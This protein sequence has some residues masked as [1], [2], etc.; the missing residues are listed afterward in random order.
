MKKT[1]LLMTFA[2]VAIFTLSL[3]GLAEAGKKAAKVRV[4]AQSID[5]R[6]ISQMIDTTER[7][8]GGNSN[9]LPVITWGGDIA[10]I[11]ANGNQKTTAAGSIFA[12]QGLSFNL[13]REDVFPKQ[14]ES[15][16]KCESPYL[17]GTMGM[18]NM[19]AEAA[20]RDSRTKMVVVYQHTW[21]AGGDVMVV[22][23]NVKNVKSLK[24]RYDYRNYVVDI[25]KTPKG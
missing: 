13:M 16:L 25:Y 14:V 23:E 1:R 5:V 12:Q 4:K 24:G 20:D 21:S 8:C 3:F 17:R 7:G 11:L 6:P 9:H 19:A 22:K 2:L 15:Y 18:I 10:T